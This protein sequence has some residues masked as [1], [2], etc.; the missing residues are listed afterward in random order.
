MSPDSDRQ[1]GARQ[2]LL[3]IVDRDLVT[4]RQPAETLQSRNIEAD[5]A[6]EDW[7]HGLDA[8]PLPASIVA[9]LRGQMPAID[10]PILLNVNEGIDVCSDMQRPEHRLYRILERRES[11]GA[12]R[13]VCERHGEAHEFWIVRDAR[14]E[15]EP[16]VIDMARLGESQ[17]ASHSGVIDTRKRADRVCVSRIP[18]IAS[19]FRLRFW[20]PVTLAGDRPSGP[21]N[22]PRVTLRGLAPVAGPS[23]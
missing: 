15:L 12:F 20:T 9:R 6:A 3:Q 5:R 23:A 21:A 16:E 1:T 8:V 7:R 11:P 17:R 18:R 19:H 14:I 4:V 22:A 2:F 13:R 10:A